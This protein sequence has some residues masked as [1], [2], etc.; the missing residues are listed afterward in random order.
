MFS[1]AK[2]LSYCYARALIIVFTSLVRDLID[3]NNVS[4]KARNK[5]KLTAGRVSKRVIA[6][7]CQYVFMIEKSEKTSDENRKNPDWLTSDRSILKDGKNPAREKNRVIE[8]K[9][10]LLK[11][12]RRSSL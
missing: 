3:C 10:I 8:N 11:T 1:I 9:M 6:K 12:K 5:A 7:L 4:K 2:Y